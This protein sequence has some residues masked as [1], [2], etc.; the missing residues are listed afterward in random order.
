MSCVSRG[1]GAEG[2]GSGCCRW[3]GDVWSEEAVFTPLTGG[4]WQVGSYSAPP[5]QLV[6]LSHF[7]ASSTHSPIG[8][9]DL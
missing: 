9:V 5:A 2:V 1:N 7:P 8:P 4:N 3:W 6:F